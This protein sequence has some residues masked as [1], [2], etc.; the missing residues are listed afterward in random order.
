MDV[1]EARRE[2]RLA[3]DHEAHRVAAALVARQAGPAALLLP[4]EGGLGIALA[5][6][7]EHVLHDLR[8]QKAAARRLDLGLQVRV[9][10]PGDLLLD[11]HRPSVRGT[12]ARSSG[13]RENGPILPCHDSD[14]ADPVRSGLSRQSTLPHSRPAP[15]CRRM[16]GAG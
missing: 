11:A 7:V 5:L 12:G 8:E 3:L 13:E 1:L 6:T 16:T 4:Q 9:V 15:E 14:A 2:R 10:D